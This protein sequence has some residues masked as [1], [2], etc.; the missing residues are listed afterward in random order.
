MKIEKVGIVGLGTVG[1]GTLKI[2][3]N[4]REKIH[5]K[6]GVWIDV[7][8]ACDLNIE[9]EFDFDVDRSIFTNNYNELIE[10]DEISIIVELIGGYTIAKD[11]IIKALKAGKNVVTANKALIAKYSKELFAIANSNGTKIY[12]EASVGG[13]IPIITPLQESLAGNNILSIKGIIN[14][15]ANYIL[16]EM[17]EKNIEFE[18]VLKKAQE[19]GYA[20]ADPTFDIEGIDTAHKITILASL[21]YGGYV[22][23]EKVGVKGITSITGEDI[24]F[25]NDLGYNIKL[26]ATAKKYEDEE[27]EVR[28]QPTLIS[29]KE[30]LSNVNDVYNAIEVIGDYVGKTMFYGKGAG[31]EPTGSAVVADVIKLATEDLAN[32][33]PKGNYY[34]NINKE[35]SLRALE[36]SISKY[37][38]RLN[39]KDEI[40]T[41]AF[42]TNKF[43]DNNISIESMIQTCKSFDDNKFVSLIFITHDVLEADLKKSLDEIYISENVNV[44]K[45]ILLKIDE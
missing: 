27:I 19:L 30:I 22:D 7:K 6:T 29:Q 31:M 10:D 39:V 26:L 15:T 11:I 34:Y 2:L 41:L 42:V 40:G 23:F 4:E 37:Y 1:T 38:I 35:L 43:K 20:E 32:N 25:A 28:V 21:A 18:K 14:G 13:G 9:R 17:T 45:S 3:I 36:K 12:Y 5:Q 24:K 44:E 33:I 8:K 16:T